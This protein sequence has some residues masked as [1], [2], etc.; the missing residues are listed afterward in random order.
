MQA[1][2]QLRAQRLTRFLTAAVLTLLFSLPVFGQANFGRVL[3]AVTDQTGGALVGATVIVTDTQRGISRTLTTDSSGQYVAPNLLPG[4]YSVRAEAKGF[5]T[6]TQSKILLEV[7]KD[8]RIDMS[9]QPGEATQ[10]I[11]IVG[12]APLVET[13][14]A[15]L[16][17]TVSNETI[18]DLPLNGRDFINLLSLRPG[19]EV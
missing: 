9:L 4:T 15:T 16:G 12:E 17:G 13:T 14:N 10:E 3:G 8:A 6:A 18:N 5:K 19:M 7:G 11:T 1:Y 2:V